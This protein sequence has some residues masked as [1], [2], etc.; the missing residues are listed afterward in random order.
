MWY[1]K[2]N[3]KVLQRSEGFPSLQSFNEGELVLGNTAGSGTAA[4]AAENTGRKW[5]CIEQDETYYKIATNRIKDHTK[6]EE[7]ITDENFEWE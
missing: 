7:P 6:T 3:Q 4:I 2:R 5:I 1:K